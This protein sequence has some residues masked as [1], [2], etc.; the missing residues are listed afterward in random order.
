MNNTLKTNQATVLLIDDEQ[1]ILDVTSRVL[2]KMGHKVYTAENGPSSFEIYTKYQSQ[3][4]LVILD[5]MMPEM[6][7]RDVYLH[8]KAINPDVKVLLSSGYEMT[9]QVQEI[10]DLG[11]SG[12]I[13]KPFSIDDL[14]RKIEELLS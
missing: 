10:L 2:Y 8:L 13:H 7:G 5:V 4:D 9:E 1:L 12:F 3:I 11:C 6:N 14:S